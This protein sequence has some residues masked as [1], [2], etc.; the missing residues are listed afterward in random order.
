MTPAV[1]LFDS[2]RTLEFDQ[3]LHDL[4][5][6][7]KAFQKKQVMTMEEMKN[8]VETLSQIADNLEAALTELDVRNTAYGD[9]W[10]GIYTCSFPF[11]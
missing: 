3:K 10:Y 8:N 11:D 9:L 4:D 2:L 7:I 1:S 6:E 5:M